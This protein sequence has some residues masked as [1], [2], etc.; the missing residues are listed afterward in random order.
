[1]ITDV[2]VREAAGQRATIYDTVGLT[3]GLTYDPSVV[4]NP[5]SF[6]I[7]FYH[8]EEDEWIDD[9]ISNVTVNEVNRT[10]TFRT[11]HLTNFA[12]VPSVS[13]DDGGSD[14]GSSSDGDGGTCIIE[15]SPAPSWMTDDLRNA[16]DWM[17][18]TSLGRWM[19]QTYY[20]SQ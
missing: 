20:S 7:R 12:S 5:D 14:S 1:M 9:G 10:I 11:T 2:T 13:T 8:G 15:R 19:T 17:M 16:R 6:D 3:A 18:S 4:D